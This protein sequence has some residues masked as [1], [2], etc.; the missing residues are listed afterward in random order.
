MAVRG[1]LGGRN[2]RDYKTPEPHPSGAT[3]PKIPG[4][5]VPKHVAV[6]MDGNGRWAKE[7]GLP[8]TEGHKVG[9]GVVMDVLKGCIEMGVKNLSL[10]AFSTENW[11]RS[12]DEVKFLMDFN[13]DVI[14][15]RRDEMDELGIRIRWVG[16]MP[17]LWK[18]VVQELQVAQEQTKDNDRMTLYF[19]VNYG[20][21]AEIADAAQRIAQDV[22]AGKL[23]PSK[24]NEKT[25]AKY[26]YYPDMPDVDLFV[27]PSGEQRTSN[28]LIWQSAYAEMVFQDVLWPDF[29]RRDLWRACLEFARRDRR[30]GGAEEKAVQKA[31]EAAEKAGPTA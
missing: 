26:I 28:Y 20:G 21:R 29:D 3:P 6:V 18:S 5:L 30:F 23:D 9:E 7:R 12:P 17:K 22:A 8:R 15:R 10:Y 2:R 4:D 14:R 25:F 27:R 16:R 11:K 13:R 19:C 31:A 24:V 1:M